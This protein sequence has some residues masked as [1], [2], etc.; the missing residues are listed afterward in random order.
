MKDS[1][2]YNRTML[3]QLIMKKKFSVSTGNE[4]MLLFGNIEPSRKELIAKTAIPLVQN[5]NTEQEALQR[6]K[7]LIKSE[8]MA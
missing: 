2:Y 8:Q 7:E 3:L 6:V 4:I 1:I 5:S